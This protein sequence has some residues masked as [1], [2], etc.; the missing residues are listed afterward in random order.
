MEKIFLVTGSDGHLGST[1]VKQLID[2]G[3]KVRGLRMRNSTLKTPIIEEV[4][5]GDVRDFE[6]MNEF[7][8]VENA[9][10]IHTA[11]IIN[12][13][14]KMNQRIYDTNVNGCENII[15]HSKI[16][17][18]RLIYVSSVHAINFDNYISKNDDEPYPFKIEVDEKKDAYSKT[19]AIATNLV[20]QA[21]K[22]EDKIDFNIVYPAGIMGPGDYGNNIINQVIKEYLKNRITT[23]ID[24]GYNL[25]DVRSAANAIVSLAMNDNLKNREYLLT[26]NYISIKDLFNTLSDLTNIKYPKL[27]LPIWLLKALIPLTTIYFR[28]KKMTP[29]YCKYSLE[30]LSERID[31]NNNESIRDLKLKIFPLKKTLLDTINFYRAN[32]LLK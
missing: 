13:T 21:S 27:T 31:F 7:F 14:K 8:N 22:G 29:L 25:I 23:Y 16:I 17:K 30:T 15:K 5:Y 11:G 28:I 12:I 3:A 32:K 24:G 10:V 26:G 1:I 18:A 9:V 19:K 4:Y 2:R 6:S 20:R